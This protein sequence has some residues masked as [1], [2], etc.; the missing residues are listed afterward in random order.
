MAGL[1]FLNTASWGAFANI[2]PKSIVHT[3]G[4]PSNEIFDGSKSPTRSVKLNLYSTPHEIASLKLSI[5]FST[6]ACSNSFPAN[7]NLLASSSHTIAY[8][9]SSVVLC[10][11]PCTKLNVGSLSYLHCIPVSL[12]QLFYSPYAYSVMSGDPQFIILPYF[13]HNLAYPSYLLVC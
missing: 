9:C 7:T 5:V 13:Y 6:V 1:L 12:H 11:S 8:G 4:M 10:Q 3:L 2:Y